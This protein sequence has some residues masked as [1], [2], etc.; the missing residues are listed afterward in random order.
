MLGVDL[1]GRPV[2]VTGAGRGLGRAIS[3]ACG[4]AGAA[5]EVV[6]VN[7][8]FLEDTMAQ[9]EQAG[10]RARGHVC[11]ISQDSEVATFFRGLTGSPWAV[12]NNAALADGVGGSPFWEIET[13]EWERI[14]RVN[15]TG[16][17]LFS[18][19]AALAMIPARRGRIVNMASDAAL[20]GSPRLGHYIA[21]KGGVVALT[22]GMAREL[23][24]HDITVNAIAPGLT[25]GPSSER[26][27]EHRHQL[28]ADNR[29]LNR[30]QQP[31]DVVGLTLFLLSDQSAYMTGQTIVV[32]GG[33]VMP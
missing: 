9:L 8:A 12:V 2:V 25:V 29:A 13:P 21:A 15:L 5:L 11:D 31:D 20:Y 18:K 10:L 27:P 19:Y 14:L 24:E 26:I 30:T 1:S 16:T 33:F 22:R 6:D 3:V 28:Y 32:D 7:R 23:G 17:W 4:S